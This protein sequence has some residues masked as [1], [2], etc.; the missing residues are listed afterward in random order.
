MWRATAFPP[1]P[2]LGS[3]SR[4]TEVLIHTGMRLYIIEQR[5]R[6]WL[7]HSPLPSTTERLVCMC[8]CALFT[9]KVLCYK[10]SIALQR[11]TAHG[12]CSS[13]N[14][15]SLWGVTGSRGSEGVSV[16]VC[17]PNPGAHTTSIFAL[18][19][20]IYSHMQVCECVLCVCVCGRSCVVPADKHSPLSKPPG[21]IC[22]CTGAG[23]CCQ[24]H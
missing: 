23:L 14:E 19:V 20:Y 1:S 9:R 21:E 18:Y 3:T 22:L 7:V 13:G 11:L 15:K 12:S 10:R 4:P 2:T 5:V 8:V 6:V 16:C 17:G 24:G